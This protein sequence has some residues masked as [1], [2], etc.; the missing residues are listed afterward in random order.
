MR[1]R[2]IC[3]EFTWALNFQVE[4]SNNQTMDN[5]NIITQ[6][7][8]LI[9]IFLKNPKV[10]NQEKFQAQITD[11]NKIYISSY[12]IYADVSTSN[13]SDVILIILIFL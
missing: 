7:K 10:I 6:L 13:N 1:Y 2:K 4:L 8:I 12:I 9:R 11:W 3:F 5:D